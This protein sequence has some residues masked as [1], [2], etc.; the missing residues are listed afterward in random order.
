MGRGIGFLSFEKAA[1]EC[2]QKPDGH[3]QNTEIGIRKRSAATVERKE[4]RRHGADASPDDLDGGLVD[5]IHD[6]DVARPDGLHQRG[7]LPCHHTGTPP[8]PGPGGGLV[9]FEGEG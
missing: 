9:T 8:P 5:L 7:V 4:M 2:E 1:Q 6:E 3:H